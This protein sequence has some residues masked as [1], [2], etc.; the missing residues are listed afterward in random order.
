MRSTQAA[1]EAGSQIRIFLGTVCGFRGRKRPGQLDGVREDIWFVRWQRCSAGI[2]LSSSSFTNS[3][4]KVCSLPVRKTFTSSTS[5]LS[6]AA[7]PVHG[8]DLHRERHGFERL[9]IHRN[10]QRNRFDLG[11][12][13]AGEIDMDDVI[14]VVVDGVFEL[15][16]APASLPGAVMIG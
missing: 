8:A 13:M 1:P 14:G 12:A 2:F 5:A 3:A 9:A 6:G 4:R 15:D 11:A 7:L 16:G 10:H